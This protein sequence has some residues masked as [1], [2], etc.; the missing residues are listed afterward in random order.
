MAKWADYLISEVSYGENNLITK[1]M[2][3][4]DNGKTISQG[5]II[6]RDTLTNN[7]G[8]GAKYMTVYSASSRFKVGKN[9]KYFRAFDGHYIRIDNNKVNHDNLGDLPELGESHLLQTMNKPEETPEVAADVKP[10]V[11]ADVKPEVA[12]DVKPEVAADVKPEVAADVKP[13]DDIIVKALKVAKFQ[14][15]EP[16]PV[17]KIKPK[18]KAKAKPKAKAKAKP[19]AKAKAKPKAKRK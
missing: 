9:V 13:G 4:Q 11:A 14:S 6:D 1:I 19:K 10:E 15:S 18:A 2:Q 12:A 7:L 16:D 3:H 8:H 17:I 5:E